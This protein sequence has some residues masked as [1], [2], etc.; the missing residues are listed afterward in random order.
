VI[1]RTYPIALICLLAAPLLVAQ[2]SE[3][4]NAQPANI[5]GSWQLSWQGRG[6]SPQATIQLQEDG[7][8]LSGTFQDSG[9]SSSQLT[10]S[11]AG[12]NVSFSL[13]V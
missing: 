6:G 7:S 2:D 9:G 11:V 3:P 12:N 10:G 1:K 5:N 4:N 13:Q 8:K